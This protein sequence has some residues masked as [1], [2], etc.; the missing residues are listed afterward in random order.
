MSTLKPIMVSCAPAG[1]WALCKVPSHKSR[2]NL[3]GNFT[4]TFWDN[5]HLTHLI[6]V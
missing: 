3:S 2:F 6:S 1:C 4:K 5:S